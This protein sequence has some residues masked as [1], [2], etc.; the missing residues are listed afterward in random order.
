MS[1]ESVEDPRLKKLDEIVDRNLEE[2]QPDKSGVMTT[3]LDHYK[4]S[5]LTVLDND[6]PYRA[7]FFNILR[8][9][10]STDQVYLTD[11]EEKT[12]ENIKKGA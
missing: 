3:M 2:L 6:S 8:E 5:A 10:C 11:G 12:L 7:V 4:E 1:S 9:F